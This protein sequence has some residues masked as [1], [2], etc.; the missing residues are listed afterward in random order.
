MTRK[1]NIAIL[2]IDEIHHINHFITVAIELAKAHNVTIITYPGPH[3]Y[4]YGKLKEHNNTAVKVEERQTQAFRAFTDWLKNRDLPRKGFWMSKNHRYILANFDAIIFTDY[5]HQK[6]LK[7]RKQKANPKFIKF[8]HG[9]AG[10]GYVYKKDLLDFDLHVVFGE[11]Y[12]EQLKQKKLLSPTTKIAGYPKLDAVA[13]QPPKQFFDNSKPTVLYNPH[14]S[15]PFSSW[16]DHGLAILEHF[17]NQNHYNLIFAP[18]INLFTDKGGEDPA[19]IPSKYRKATHMFID[20]GSDASVEMVY[21]RAADI[22]LG[23]VSSQVYEF[24]IRPRPVLFFNS[25]KINFKND[26]N[27]RFWKCGEVIESVAAL[28]A[29]LKQAQKKFEDYKPIQQEINEGNYYTEEGSTA[30]QRAA[31]IVIDYLALNL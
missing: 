15:P 13:V 12:Y 1:Y 28:P 27:Y 17:Y 3:E 4:L 23:D 8:P 18:H 19:I 26:V 9:V 31:N 20:L 25:E 7:Y 21:T 29:A 24:I 6:L 10:R 16:H 22:Y 5:T 14:F 2:F 30:S 11:F